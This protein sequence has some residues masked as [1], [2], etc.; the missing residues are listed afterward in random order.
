MPESL[1][2]LQVA[3]K[4][5]VHSINPFVWLV[6]VNIDASN[7]MYL[8][9]YPQHVMHNGKQYRAFP[10]QVGTQARS[11]QGK[12]SEVEITVSNL[13][14]EV[15]AYLEQD[16]ILDQKCVIAAVNL[17]IP[18]QQVH[19]SVFTVIGA[20]VG[21]QAAVFRCGQFNLFSAAFPANRYSRNRCRWAYGQAG[22]WYNL[23]L[24]NL[25]SG[26]NP[27]FAPA[28]C[29]LGLETENGCIVHGLNELANGKPVLHPLM[30]GGQP[31]IPKGPARV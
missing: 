28:T 17:N 30:F 10:I 15:A 22:C 24:P 20:T 3:E 13:S 2:T 14:R 31:D 29:D 4:N 11:A 27:N 25:I 8:C 19:E 1:S 9:G 23:G 6:R 18:D 26:T 12:L 16:K 7:A 21:R 5:K